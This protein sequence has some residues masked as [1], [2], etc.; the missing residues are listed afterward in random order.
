MTLTSSGA[1]YKT[2]G[3]R[4]QSWT[5]LLNAYADLGTWW[6]LTPYVGA[7]VGLTHIHADTTE[8]WFWST[9]A[10][11]GSGNN[12]YDSATGVS[13]HYGYAGNVGSLQVRNNFSF[14]LMTGIAYDIAPHLKLDIGYRY[15]NMG[16]LSVIDTSGYTVRKTVDAQEVRA[17]LRWTPDL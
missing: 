7:G 11:Y 13:V 5:A 17:G 15:L 12:T 6:N 8:N 14:A 9:G 3:V 4:T 1:C 16:S 10:P 2:D